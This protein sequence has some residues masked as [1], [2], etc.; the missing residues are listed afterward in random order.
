MTVLAAAAA[1]VLLQ[2]CK[3]QV[4]EFR[5][6]VVANGKI[7]QGDKNKPFDG[8]VTNIPETAIF[9]REAEIALLRPL[10]V[11]ESTKAESNVHFRSDAV[12]K[13]NVREGSLHGQATCHFPRSELVRSVMSFDQG[14]L[15]GPV[16][17]KGRPPTG[18][19][20]ASGTFDA[21]KLAGK[22][23]IF[24]PG[25]GKPV[26]EATWKGGMLD[27]AETAWDPATGK[28]VG[29]ATYKGGKLDGE[30]KRYASDGERVTYRSTF[31][32]GLMEGLEEEFDPQNGRP[33][34]SVEWKAGKK[35]GLAREWNWP[36]QPPY[37]SQCDQGN[38]VLTKRPEDASTQPPSAAKATDE[39]AC[40]NKWIVAHRKHVGE[41]ASVSA[42]Q[43]GE[44][45]EWC[46]QGKTPA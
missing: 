43:L 12:C 37:E 19:L 20:I 3:P 32:N 42:D 18:H 31:N 40:V 23:Q 4:L 33:L 22:H 8:E 9:P 26:W 34:K 46:S 10:G 44:W 27:G 16:T 29:S 41:D 14:V 30:V 6:V 36:G 11:L 7:Y 21:G 5:N 17:V 25:S 2:G 38:C 1:V 45:K 15:S 35:H 28:V 39:N 24:H 13:V